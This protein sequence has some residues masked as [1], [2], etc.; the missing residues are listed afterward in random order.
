MFLGGFSDILIDS[1]ANETA[2]QFIR[3]KIGRIVKDPVIAKLL[4]PE[5]QVGCKRLCA[6]SGYY[7]TFNRDNVSLIDVATDPIKEITN[8]G[9][10]TKDKKFEFDNLIMATGFD[11]MTGAV[12]KI[13]ITGT[14]GVSLQEKWAE[15]ATAYLGLSTHNFPNLFTVTGPGSPSVLTNMIPSIEQHV[16]WI[17]DCI[18]WLNQNG[19]KSIEADADAEK[20]W[21]IHVNEVANATI[22]PTCNSWYLGA[23]IPGKTRTFLPYLGF[24]TYVEKCD[25]IVKNN[26]EGFHCS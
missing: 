7:D 21:A 12:T 18:D 9:L 16:N 15:N 25:T 26:Y 17:T 24:P 10:I 22:F 2:A 8:D 5:H 6:D 13:K 4:M 20:A 19:Y 1:A 11:A 23:N 3:K 14:H